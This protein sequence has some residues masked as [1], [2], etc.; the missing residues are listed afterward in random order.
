[1]LWRSFCD[2]TAGSL[3]TLELE[4]IMI[5][6][7]SFLLLFNRVYFE[8]NPVQTSDYTEPCIFLSSFAIVWLI[9]WFLIYIAESE[10]ETKKASV[11]AFEHT[12]ELRLRTPVYNVCTDEKFI[13]H[14]FEN[15]HFPVSRVANSHIS[16]NS[17]YRRGLSA[18]CL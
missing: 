16:S 5:D 3:S 10:S 6:S 12:V 1:M 14:R 9:R 17:L 7:E 18:H 15:G 13:G 8:N 2:S 11:C 4:D